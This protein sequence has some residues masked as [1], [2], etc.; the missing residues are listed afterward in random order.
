[1]SYAERFLY[2]LRSALIVA[3][4]LSAANAA[5]ATER[6]DC[7]VAP[8]FE[9][10]TIDD[11][12]I[13]L[14]D[15]KGEKPVYLK[16]WLSTCPQCIAEMPHFVHAYEQYGDELQFVAVNLAMDGDTPNIVRRAMVEHGLEMPVVVDESSHM[17]SAFGI[18]GTPTHIVI[19][20]QGRIVY[21][22]N[23]ADD[24]LDATLGCIYASKAGDS[25]MRRDNNSGN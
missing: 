5:S 9:T 14:Q 17:Q 13:A 22:S 12:R 21:S 1:M 6:D 15:L 20:R 18:F 4:V 11:E 7:D 10:V 24:E 8:E 2:A 19:D 25:S 23:R 16:F 3:V